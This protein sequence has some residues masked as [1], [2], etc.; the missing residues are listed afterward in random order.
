MIVPGSVAVRGFGYG[1]LAVATAGWMVI[2]PVEQ[3][4]SIIHLPGTVTETSEVA[5]ISGIIRSV[6]ALDEL[7]VLSGR[8]NDLVTL[9]G[10]IPVETLKAG[11]QTASSSVSG[12]IRVDRKSAQVLTIWQLRGIIAEVDE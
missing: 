7:E 2:A 12:F 5:R 6:G 9:E 4:G 11:M 8:L 10:S 3:G 1:A